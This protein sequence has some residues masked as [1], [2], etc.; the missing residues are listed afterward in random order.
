MW[1]LRFNN[2]H[3]L[4]NLLNELKKSDK[5]RDLPILLSLFRNQFNKF[6]NTAGHDVRSYLSRDIKITWKLNSWCEPDDCSLY[7]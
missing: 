6:R 7:N 4:L 5:M 1:N 3:I 2:A